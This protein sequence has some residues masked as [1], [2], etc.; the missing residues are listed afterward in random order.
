MSDFPPK[1]RW[2][3]FEETSIQPDKQMADSFIVGGLQM[4]IET[5]TD[6][7]TSLEQELTGRPP[8]PMSE[9]ASAMPAGGHLVGTEIE[10]FLYRKLQYPLLRDLMLFYDRVAAASLTEE[11]D[12][13]TIADLHET[14]LSFREEIVDM[15]SEQGIERIEP[16]GELDPACH[17]VRQSIVTDDPAQHNRVSRVVRVGFARHGQVMRKAEVEV[18]RH[19]PPGEG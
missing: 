3:V 18:F 13:L 19:R 1:G 16:D 7:I 14:I 11:Q 8:A 9:P 15:L 4:A 5:L 6:R 17:Q 10:D 2:K 12:D